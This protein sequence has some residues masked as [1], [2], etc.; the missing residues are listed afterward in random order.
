MTVSALIFERCVNIAPEA[1]KRKKRPLEARLEFPG[2]FAYHD[3][4]F[5]I[6]GL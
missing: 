6:G 3:S 2:K 1:L 5:R 4:V